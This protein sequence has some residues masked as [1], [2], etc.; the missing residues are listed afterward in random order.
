M[1]FKDTE[2]ARLGSCEIDTPLD[3]PMF[4]NENE[5]VVVSVDY[6]IIE[7]GFKSEG[8]SPSFV[9]AGPR[10]K[11]FFSAKDT[12][13]AILTCGGL[14][15]GINNVVKSIV[16]Q[17]YFQ[18]NVK[19]IYGVRY[20]YEGLIPSYGHELVKL[21]PEDIDDIH[22]K[23]GSVLASSRGMQ[24]VPDMVDFLEKNKIDILFAI[25]GDGTLTGANAIFGEVTRRRLKIAIVGVPKTI[26]NDIMYVDR[27]FGFT[28]AVSYA[29]NAVKAAH[30]EAKGARNGI[31]LVKVMGRDSG[32]I[33]SYAAL[34]S[35]DVNYVFIPEVSFA[36]NGE[37]G[38]LEHLHK[39]LKMRS[40]AVV[41]VAEGAGQEYFSGTKQHDASGNIK[42][43][44]F[45]IFMRET[46]TD[47]FKKKDFHINLK[48]IDPSYI[49]RS[50]PASADD[51]VFCIM[52]AQNA[53]HGAMAGMTG[54]FVG[55]V[56][57]FFT[58]IPIKLVIGKRKK[59]DPNGYLWSIVKAATGQPDFV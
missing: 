50:M 28:T 7:K 37:K 4:I 59:I 52:L 36:I 31:G 49:I 38:F 13:A 45:G 42:Y 54:M 57:K 27:T 30:T 3:I 15:P 14:S 5:R 24:K 47:Y 34:A 33:A 9:N 53:V 19:K 40:H 26:D 55:R 22:E 20:G 11:I 41:L 12:T 44:D 56:N 58:F 23:G 1:N 51:A 10:K 25:G 17:L 6:G 35:N 48:Y 32:F 21:V 8:M 18:Y 29:T 2:V 16:S 39:R 46:I 43:G